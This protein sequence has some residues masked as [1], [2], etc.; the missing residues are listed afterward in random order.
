MITVYIIH[1]DS[2][3]TRPRGPYT[4][5][6]NRV[7]SFHGAQSSRPA[8]G[9]VT[10]RHSQSLPTRRPPWMAEYE[11]KGNKKNQRK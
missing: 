7:E 6:A 4:Q 1:A 11:R 2:V 10:Y 9:G 5:W 8:L 3:S